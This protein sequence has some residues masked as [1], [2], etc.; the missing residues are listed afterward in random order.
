M[1]QKAALIHDISWQK[2]NQEYALPHSVGSLSR[3]QVSVSNMDH[4][5]SSPMAL[6]ACLEQLLLQQKS[7]ISNQSHLQVPFRLCRGVSWL[8]R[9]R[10]PL[11]SRF[12]ASGILR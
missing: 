4:H 12:K 2:P 10:G 5:G 6:A 8:V 1:F 9:S 7:A 11:M 3:P